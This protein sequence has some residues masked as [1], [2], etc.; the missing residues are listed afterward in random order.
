[1]TLQIPDPVI[2]HIEALASARFP[3][4]A[5]GLLIGERAD[6]AV[7]VSDARESR[8]IA[9]N[10]CANFEVDPGLRLRLQREL[11]GHGSE[12]VGVFHSHPSGDPAPSKTDSAAIWEPDLLW[13]I[14]AVDQGVVGA[15]QAYAIAG[16]ET[17]FS[18]RQ[19]AMER[20]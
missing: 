20:A 16:S 8:N 18:F 12:I 2:R 9:A 6:N 11:R 10:P 7:L 15:S 17:G 14:T 19:V 1:M 5:C 3:E 4:E 13:L